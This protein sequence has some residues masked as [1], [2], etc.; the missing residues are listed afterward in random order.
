VFLGRLV[1]IFSLKKKTSFI[2]RQDFMVIPF[3]AVEVYLDNVVPLDS[4]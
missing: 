1:E 3:Q 4:K 2:Y